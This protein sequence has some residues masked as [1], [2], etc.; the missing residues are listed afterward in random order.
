MQSVYLQR[1]MK[2]NAD[3]GSKKTKPKQTQFKK[4]ICWMRT[5]IL[6]S[7]QLV[8]IK[9]HA[10][11]AVM[12]E[13]QYWLALR[14]VGCNRE[15][16]AG[17]IQVLMFGVSLII[18]PAAGVFVAGRAAGVFS[19]PRFRSHRYVLPVTVSADNVHIFLF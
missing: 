12:S 16:S 18:A 19:H 17:H 5:T 2:N 14:A 10:L 15:E 7:R 9:N 6:L 1:I 13:G 3:M 11:N 4:G 8:L